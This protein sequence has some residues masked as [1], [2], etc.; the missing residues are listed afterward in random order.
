MSAP[1]D[2]RLID[3]TPLVGCCGRAEVEQAVALIVRA[4]QVMGN[5]WQP[6]AWPD[7]QK[8]LRADIEAKTPPFA[9]LVRNPFFNPDVHDAIRGGFARWTTADE[10]GGPVEL[11]PACLAAIERWAK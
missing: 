11:T 9:W 10:G 5:R 4:C 3:A 2:I 6:V 8:V 1:N 7:I